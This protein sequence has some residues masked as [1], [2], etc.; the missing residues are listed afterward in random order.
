MIQH[1]NGRIGPGKGVDLIIDRPELQARRHRWVY[2][3]LTLVAWIVWMYLW[4][5]AVTLVAWSFG[6]RVFLREVVVP[7]PATVLTVLTAYF[8]VIVLMGASLIIW[9]RYNLERF[10]GQ[11]R[12]KKPPE[13][14]DAELREMF[15][16]SVDQ[17]RCFRT[18]RT[19]VVEHGSEGEVASVGAGSIGW[20][21]ADVGD[22][23][24]EPS[25]AG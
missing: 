7:D 16:I 13:I 23:A 1:A 2:S 3:T 25:Q 11:D 15:E 20:P 19:L 18:E 9:S 8:V 24:K 6:V 17:L 4:L 14:E 5:P 12:R 22:G 21:G 10:G